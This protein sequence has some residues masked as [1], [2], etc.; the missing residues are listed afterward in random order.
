MFGWGLNVSFVNHDCHWFA[1]STFDE[2]DLSFNAFKGH[3]E[4]L[5]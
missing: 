2:D 4:N 5:S 1:V 3:R